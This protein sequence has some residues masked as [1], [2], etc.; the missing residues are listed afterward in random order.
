VLVSTKLYVPFFGPTLVLRK[1]T[2]PSQCSTTHA[3]EAFA[4]NHS[5]ISAAVIPTFDV[6]FARGTT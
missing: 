4:W 1:V 5:E 6:V 2:I 3:A